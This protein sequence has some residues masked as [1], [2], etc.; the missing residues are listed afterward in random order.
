VI[1]CPYCGQ[2]V[3]DADKHREHVVPSLIGGNL[4]IDAC[5]KCDSESAVGVDN[6]ILKTRQV[7]L[8]RAMYDVRSHRTPNAPTK[9]QIPATLS[10][11]GGRVMW[12][13]GPKRGQLVQATPSQP[14][15]HRDGDWRIATPAKTAV[16]DLKQ[17][18]T[19]LRAEHPGRVVKVI[20]ESNDSS[21]LVFE[22]QY[23][24]GAGWEWPRFAA[25]IGLA[26][27]HLALGR[28]FSLSVPMQKL[29][30]LLRAGSEPPGIYPP[31]Q[32]VTTMVD[33]DPDHAAADVL[34]PHEHIIG[35]EQIPA[36]LRFFGVLFGEI[37]FQVPLA[38]S[39]QLPDGDVAWLLGS[40]GPPTMRRAG[41]VVA[42]LETRR[43]EIGGARQF[44][45][46]AKLDYDGVIHRIRIA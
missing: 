11:G 41:D 33:N 1:F 7:E 14:Y 27:G 32:R 17:A 18:L 37:A 6:V 3:D 16:S 13:P 45:V 15:R 12:R 5:G 20:D 10:V 9:V 35:I 38:T 30:H 39:A 43:D 36:G 4:I 25:K 8:C 44:H 28:D 42:Q 31:D 26:M 24:M 40:D 2:D 22:H 19:A 46:T 23:G 34:L 29:R 21:D